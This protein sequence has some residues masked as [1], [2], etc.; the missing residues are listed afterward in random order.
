[1]PDCQRIFD[2]QVHTDVFLFRKRQEDPDAQ[3]VVMQVSDGCLQVML[4][5]HMI[6]AGTHHGH[7]M[8]AIIS[9]T[10]ESP[11]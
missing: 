3:I 6:H 8:A 5:S 1:M 10:S 4:R 9:E 2:E 7:S 11:W